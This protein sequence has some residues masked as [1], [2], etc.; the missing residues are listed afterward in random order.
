MLGSGNGR[1]ALHLGWGRRQIDT[2]LGLL[3]EEEQVG[4]MEQAFHRFGTAHFCLGWTPPFLSHKLRSRPEAPSHETL[5]PHEASSWP[6]YTKCTNYIHLPPPFSTLLLLNYDGLSWPIITT[7]VS[8]WGLTMSMP[9]RAGV[10][11]RKSG[12]PWPKQMT[13]GPK[14]STFLSESL[15]TTRLHAKRL[16]GSR[17]HGG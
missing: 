13:L 8:P 15:L 16:G 5:T 1:L 10:C 12:G 17:G 11:S 4:S 7:L 6:Q 2:T 9:A 3:R 14:S